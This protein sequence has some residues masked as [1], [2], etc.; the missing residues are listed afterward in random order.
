MKKQESKFKKVRI[1]I[2]AFFLFLSFLAI[3]G[4]LYYLQIVQH[5][6]YADYSRE[7][8]F[9]KVKIRATRADI[10]DRHANPLAL[11]L[12]V[13][14]VFVRP[15]RLKNA[16]A[17]AE[18]LSENLH[19]QRKALVK[20]F[21]KRKNFVW[22]KRK[23]QDNEYHSLKK[24]GLK[25][26]SFLTE[27][28]RFYPYGTFAARVIGFTGIDNQGLAG[29]EHYYDGILKGE[30]TTYM[31]KRDALGRVYGFADGHR[32]GG[33][34]EMITTIDTGIQ[35]AAEKYLKETFENY[36][37]RG[38]V[39]I[40]M[41]VHSGGILAMAEEPEIDPNFYS[42]FSLDRYKSI[43]VTTS[44]EPGSTFKV[45]LAA[46]ALDAG[47][48]S[49]EDIFDCENGRLKIGRKIIR[50]ASGESFGLLSFSEIITH[51]SNIGAIK[52]G[53]R[54]GRE[55][56]YEYI[57]KFGFGSR[58]GIDL[59]GEIT[60]ILRHYRTWSEMSLPSISFG[61]E[62]MVTPIQLITALSAIGNGGMSVQPHFFKA[63]VRDGKIFKRYRAA[64]SRRVISTK[65]AWQSVELMRLVV[66]KGTGRMAHMEGFSLAGKTGTAQKFDLEAK[67][68]SKDKYVASFMA[69]FPAD[70]PVIAILVMLDEP[71][72]AGWG[73]QVA[74]PVAKK[75]AEDAAGILSI[76]SR[77]DARY[78][79]DWNRMEK[80]H[81]SS[82]KQMP[83]AK[84]GVYEEIKNLI[85][86]Y[87]GSGE[88]NL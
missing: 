41:D 38:G 27:E 5:D 83:S 1:G 84:T 58:T 88:K 7:Q 17:T 29:L 32:P 59:P 33:K 11:S 24:K 46:A 64:P 76:P 43:S 28:K 16:S 79:V 81:F 36:Q 63:A 19:L 34:F 42:S 71:A 78:V 80:N 47:V 2:T 40:V 50:E 14:S 56:F 3:G 25:G 70:K 65:A 44:F 30:K 72:G 45:F 82:P 53:R 8:Y 66:E 62:I 68:Y 86:G 49:P 37:A 54:L 23:I 51:S 39:A 77:M 22:V 48:A 20:K 57:K 85:A 10:L 69:L 4:K 74:A 18:I 9:R 75:I 21:S 26:V 61:Q 73:G 35:H 55:R 52:I 15:F 13:K 87:A 67:Q 60:G 31:A 6:L 12:P